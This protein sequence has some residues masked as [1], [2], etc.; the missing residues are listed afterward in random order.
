M[1]GMRDAFLTLET[2]PEQLIQDGEGTVY[3]V[4]EMGRIRFQQE[5]GE[6]LEVSGVLFVSDSPF[7]PWR[8][9][10]M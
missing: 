5:F 6:L 9:Q 4:R 1:I 8:V 10:G 3:A 2:I 7:Q